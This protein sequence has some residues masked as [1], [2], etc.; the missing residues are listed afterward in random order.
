MDGFFKEDETLRNVIRTVSFVTNNALVVHTVFLTMLD[1]F[2]GEKD[3]FTTKDA[4]DWRSNRDDEI[5]IVN[6]FRTEEDSFYPW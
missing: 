1:V 5:S 3:W 2:L 4:N 6:F